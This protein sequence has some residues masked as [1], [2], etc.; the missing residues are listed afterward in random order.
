MQWIRALYHKPLAHV[1]TN[2][3][4]S[5]PLEL[6]RSTRQGCPVSPIIFILVLEPLACAIRANQLITGINVHGYDFKINIYA[7]DI[8]L[9]LSK[10]DISICKIFF[11]DGPTVLKV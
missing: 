4:V 3:I 6:S 5:Q 2:G 7:D 10:P 8:L 1:K 9:T 11:S